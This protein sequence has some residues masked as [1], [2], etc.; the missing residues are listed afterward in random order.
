M[1]KHFDI[2]VYHD[3]CSDGISALW[4]VTHSLPNIKTIK[5]KAGC[6]DVL[7]LEIFEN[8]RVIFVDICPTMDNLVKISK[9]AN[10]I[11]VLDHHDSSVKN[12][13]LYYND[14]DY[15]GS[16]HDNIEIYLDMTRSG[17][18]MA[19]DYFNLSI[20]PNKTRPW[21]LNYVADR[22]LWQWKLEHSKEYNTAFFDLGYMTK[23]KINELYIMNDS[24]KQE[25]LNYGIDAVKKFNDTVD[26]ICKNAC[27]ARIGDYNCWLLSCTYKYR[28][29]V[30]NRLANIRLPSNSLPDFTAI[31]T[32]DPNS[33][34]KWISLR[35]IDGL[36]LSDVCKEFDDKGGGHPRAAGFTIYDDDLD[37]LFI[38]EKI[39]NLDKYITEQL[40]TK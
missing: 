2:V 39:T 10:W 3:P 21:F 31:W 1:N 33:N 27:V 17:C 9:V 30:G 29:D 15:L 4:A 36:N 26:N 25:L 34:N 20:S 6:C 22:D 28:S 7:D 19:W 16:V 14:D 12:Y 24:K 13:K 32:C 35:N 5:C 38:I 18:Q 23:S 40:V 37:S 11:T 8:K